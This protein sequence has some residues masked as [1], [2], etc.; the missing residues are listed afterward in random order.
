MRLAKRIC[1]TGDK[2]GKPQIAC[3][4]NLLMVLTV[5]IQLFYSYKGIELFN[6]VYETGAGANHLVGINV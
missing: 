2:S 1:E 4:N 3:L 5:F 6:C